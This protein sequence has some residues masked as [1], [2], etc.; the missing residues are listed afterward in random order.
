M[1]YRLIEL[2]KNNNIVHVCI[3][4]YLLGEMTLD[5]ALVEC[6]VLLA[7]QNKDLFDLLVKQEIEN[8]IPLIFRTK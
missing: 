1:D 8:P 6:V 2:N 3:T 5:Q 7:Q 4:K